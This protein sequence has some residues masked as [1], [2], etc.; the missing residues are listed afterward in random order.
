M[1]F[2]HFLEEIDFCMLN[3]RFGPSSN[4]FTS[5]SYRGSATVDYCV[6]P[7]S[8]FNL[9]TAFKIELIHDV[10]D[11]YNIEVD[12]NIPD[13]SV[14]FWEFQFSSSISSTPE[15][16]TPSLIRLPKQKIPQGYLENCKIL[17]LIDS[18]VNGCI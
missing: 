4:K 11:K 5:V 8:N 3:G 9:I 16:F 18:N 17:N 1:P 7:T 10:I 6:V 14:L 2:I 12:G 15:D 13:H